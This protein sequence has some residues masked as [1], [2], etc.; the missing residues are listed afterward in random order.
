MKRAVPLAAFVTALVLSFG[1]G[2]TQAEQGLAA[3][4]VAHEPSAPRTALPGFGEGEHPD[5]QVLLSSI[6]MT[7]S[8]IDA[9]GRCRDDA[10]SHEQCMAIIR[11]TLDQARQL[12]GR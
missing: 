10:K 11:N 12:I 9:Y 3:Q 4:T 5:L 6:D 8:L 7:V 2:A 1:F